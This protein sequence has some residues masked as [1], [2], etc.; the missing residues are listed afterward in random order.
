MKVIIEHVSTEVMLA[1]P[2]TKGML[3]QKFIDRVVTM[4][5]S[6]TM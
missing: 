2:L 4:G 3:P 1:N 6:P 5:L